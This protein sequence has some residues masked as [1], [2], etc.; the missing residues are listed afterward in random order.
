M[1]KANMI[2]AVYLIGVLPALGTYWSQ[3][4]AWRQELSYI[5]STGPEEMDMILFATG[6][7]AEQRTAFLLDMLGENLS[8]TNLPHLSQNC[9]RCAIRQLP[10][11]FLERPGCP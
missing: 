2:V 11:G 5:E 6:S 7:N 3:R 9:V 10:L 4:E 1:A 8:A